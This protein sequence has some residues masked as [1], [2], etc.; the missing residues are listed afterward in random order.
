[1]IKVDDILKKINDN[2]EL[3]K[4]AARSFLERYV[5]REKAF[6]IQAKKREADK[7]FMDRT[8]TI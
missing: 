6:V 8:Y 2:P 3:R 4:V 5:A 7:E 1:M